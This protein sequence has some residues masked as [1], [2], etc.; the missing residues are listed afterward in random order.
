LLQ[1]GQNIGLNSTVIFLFFSTLFVYNLFRILSP[2]EECK[3]W[4]SKNYYYTK[5][6]VVISFIVTIISLYFI[7]IQFLYILIIAGILSFFYASPFMEIGK[8]SFNLRKFWFLKSIIVSLVWMLT[9]S[10]FP[11]LEFGAG[12]EQLLL[13]PIEKFLFILGITIPYDIKD[14][15]EDKAVGIKTMAMKFGIKR[16][17]WISNFFLFIGMILAMLIYEQEF[18]STILVYV[19]AMFLNIKLNEEKDEF[20]YTFLIDGTIILYFVIVFLQNKV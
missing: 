16:T 11:L 4:Y 12:N 10:V 14:M 20:W 19:I 2:K 7:D 17:K 1:I 3:T 5:S 6:L 8:T 13:F 9:T 18:Y 15:K